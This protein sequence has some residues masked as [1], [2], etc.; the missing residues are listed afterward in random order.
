M[1]VKDIVEI[2]NKNT[3]FTSNIVK[4]KQNLDN[5]QFLDMS[6]EL[7][8]PLKKQ[9]YSLQVL[10]EDIKTKALIDYDKKVIKYN[11]PKLDEA[12]KQYKQWLES[13]I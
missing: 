8:E 10:E 3:E 7:A 2:I 13:E 4:Y 12:I 1:K 5:L 6:G 11:K 9:G